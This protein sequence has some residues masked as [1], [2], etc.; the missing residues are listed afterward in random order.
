MLLHPRIADLA[1]VRPPYLAHLQLF[2]YHVEPM[3][4]STFYFTLA[5]LVVIDIVQSKYRKKLMAQRKNEL[6]AAA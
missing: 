1:F 4:K 2:T 5:I 3:A 6:H